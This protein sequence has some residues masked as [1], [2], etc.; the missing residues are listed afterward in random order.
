MSSFTDA[1]HMILVEES[2]VWENR[3]PVTGEECY[4]YGELQYR[5]KDYYKAVHY[6]RKAWKEQF[7][8]AAFRL[9]DCMLEGKGIEKAD[10]EDSEWKRCSEQ[11]FHF[12]GSI[13][14]PTQEDKYRLGK[15]Y[16]YGIGTEKNLEKAVHLFDGLKAHGGALF[17]LASAYEHGYGSLE[18]DEKKARELYWLAYD[19][20]YEEAIFEHYRLSGSDFEK[21]TYQRELK[22]AYSFRIGQLMRITAI[23]PGRDAYEKMAAIYENGYPGDKGEEDICFRERAV[24]Y[25]KKAEECKEQYSYGT[26]M[27]HLESKNY[28]EW[29]KGKEKNIYDQAEFLREHLS[30]Q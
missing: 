29:I 2:S 11:A 9:A 10:R 13:L 23:A 1:E 24:E 3:L 26:F 16:A 22:E 14:N 21:Y 25:R 6:F 8:P 18:K 27:P 4:R 15:C 19:L 5:L 20:N 12:Y 7:M 17:E 30:A 28:Q